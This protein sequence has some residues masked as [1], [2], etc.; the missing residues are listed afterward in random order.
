MYLKICIRTESYAKEQ[1]GSNVLHA[2]YPALISA[3]RIKIE[4][5]KTELLAAAVAM[6]IA[7][8]FVIV[9]IQSETIM[10]RY[11]F[12]PLPRALELQ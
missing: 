12:G 3:Q 7:R 11:V 5:M 2:V 6:P 10:T 4:S 9:V 1:E 8:A